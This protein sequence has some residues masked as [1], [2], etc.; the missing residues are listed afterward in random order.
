MVNKIIPAVMETGTWVL[1]QFAG[2]VSGNVCS[3]MIFQ[4]ALKRKEN[5]NPSSE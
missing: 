5:R 3:K 2:K 1:K 4:Q